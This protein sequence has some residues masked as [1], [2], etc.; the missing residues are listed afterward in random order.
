M[1]IDPEVDDEVNCALEMA[2]VVN[3]AGGEVLIRSLIKKMQAYIPLILLW[4]PF[5]PIKNN[6]MR[7]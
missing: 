5:M 1:R 4:E 7:Q 3:I 6:M 2:T